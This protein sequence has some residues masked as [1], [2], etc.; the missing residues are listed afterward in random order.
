MIYYLTPLV[1]AGLMSKVEVNSMEAEL[2]RK[3]ELLGNDLK[4]DVIRN[5]F[6]DFSTP[7][8]DT[9]TKLARKNRLYVNEF[10]QNKTKRVF[11]IFA[12]GGE[13]SAELAKK[14][15]SAA[16]ETPFTKD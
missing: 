5:L 14:R 11:D 1:A 8:A 3:Q 7:I 16:Q 2:L 13:V 12:V 15:E 6:D 9:I 10:D 4:N